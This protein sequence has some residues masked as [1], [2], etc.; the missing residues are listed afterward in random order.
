[1]L[2]NINKM[3]ICAAKLI[4]KIRYLM[5]AEK[6]TRLEL[7]TMNN[8]GVQSDTIDVYYE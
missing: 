1:M 4:R 6:L 7:P 5:Q 3:P 2:E 8:K